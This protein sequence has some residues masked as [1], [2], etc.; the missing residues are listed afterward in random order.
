MNAP[1]GPSTFG[2]SVSPVKTFVLGT[3]GG[4]SV[5]YA[6]TGAN[7]GRIIAA[8]VRSEIAFDWT[9]PKFQLEFLTKKLLQEHL[10]SSTH[11]DSA[12][13]F[14]IVT[15]DSPAPLRPGD[16]VFFDSP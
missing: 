13:A 15:V 4:R 12:A 11:A 14:E 1:V 2:A 8:S 3:D 6:E 16:E 5:A 7:S 9:D 10:N